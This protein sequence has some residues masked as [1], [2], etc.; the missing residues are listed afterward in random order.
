MKASCSIALVT[1]CRGIFALAISLAPGAVCAASWQATA[2]AQRS[3]EGIQALA[4]LP[5]G[6]W[7]HVGDSITWT[8]P[9]PE[10]HTVTS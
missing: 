4:F 7:V 10:I 9:S 5:N 6:L 1:L 3:D 2:G 8:F